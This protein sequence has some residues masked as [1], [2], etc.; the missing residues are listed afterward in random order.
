VTKLTNSENSNRVF[1]AASTGEGTAIVAESEL[2]TGLLAN[3]GQGVAVFANTNGLEAVVAQS[4]SDTAAAIR[5]VQSSTGNN[6]TG[7]LGISG[8][9]EPTVR[10]KTGVHGYADQ[11]STSRGV[12][13][14]CPDGQGVRGETETGSAVFGNADSGYAL[15]GSGRVRFDRVS[16]VARLAAGSTSKTITPGVD[17]TSNSFVLLTPKTTSGGARCGSPPTLPP[18][19]SPST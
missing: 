2:G 4:D 3:C 11:D 12:I 5:A 8:P 17:L 19:P 9:N 1:E 6:L 15:R 16:G 14:E 13:G 18:T 7:V 10:A